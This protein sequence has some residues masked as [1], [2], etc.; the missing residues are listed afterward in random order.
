MQLLHLLFIVLFHCLFG[1]KPLKFSLEVMLPVESESQNKLLQ[2][3][4]YVSNI[5]IN[6]RLQKQRDSI[7]RLKTN[8]IKICTSL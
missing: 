2:V 1:L 8:E 4:T 5:F 3:L 6:L 7:F